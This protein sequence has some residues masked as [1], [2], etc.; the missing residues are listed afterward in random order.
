MKLF[1]KKK[2][3]TEEVEQI[4]DIEKNEDKPKKKKKKK[5]ENEKENVFTKNNKNFKDLIAIDYINFAESHKYGC[6]GEKYMKNM[7]IGITPAVANF[8]SFLHGLYNYGDIDTS[9][10][11]QPIASESAKADLSKLRTNL[12]TEYLSAG[13]SNNRRDDMAA[14]ISEA[15]R[16]RNEIRDGYNKAYEVSIQSTLYSDSVRELDNSASKLKSLLG[17]QD[18]G[19]KSATYVQETAYRSNKPFLNNLLG[20]WHTFDKRSLAC[21][22]PFTSNNINHPNGVLIGFNKDNGLPIIYD[23]FYEKLDNYNMCIFAKSGGGKSSFIKLLSARS[24]TLDNIINIALDIEPEYR[25]IAITLGGINVTIAP[26]SDT[27]LNFFDVTVE[28]VKSKVTGKFIEVVNL[29]DKINSVTSILLTMAKGFTSSNEEFYNDITRSIIKECV[30]ECYSD[31][32]ITD[33]VA[34]IFEYRM[35]D[36][37]LTKTRQV[38]LMPTLSDWYAKLQERA[39]NNKKETYV[40]YYD[41]LL[42]V[43]KEF[44]KSQNGGF[45]CFDGQSNVVLNYDS[46]F[47]NFDLS[48]L[49][50]NTELPLAQHI[51]CDY[52]WENLVKTNNKGCKIRV[53]IDE[54][55][56]MAK[57]IN[58]EPKFPEALEFLD[59]MFRR[60]R[61]KNTS[62]VIISQQFNEFYNDLTQSIIKNADTKVFL[63]PDDTSV[64]SIQEVFHLTEGETYYLKRITRGEALIKCNT[65]SAKLDIEIPPFEMEFIETNQN[66]KANKVS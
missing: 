60:A 63:P 23:T 16:L 9:I 62:T 47:I 40:K 53:L 45:T 26:T 20:S 1:K 25:D 56:R 3:V 13:E 44:I 17:T 48:G 54:A 41:Y 32:E 21:V 55:W 14:K 37:S 12:E 5:Q 46:P 4:V 34:S 57:V 15:Q 39:I 66:A 35:D 43:M 10:F 31:K 8:A 42:L 50:E 64:D 49:N 24:A 38:K 2:K 30:A 61:K 27:I 51:V 65:V 6:I 58:G 33:E 7:Y 28:T 22:F 19:L 11:I 29:Q 59:K 36:E 18:I 52:I